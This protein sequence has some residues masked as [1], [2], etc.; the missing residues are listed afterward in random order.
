MIIAHLDYFLGDFF[1]KLSLKI[2]KS[3]IKH[4]FHSDVQVTADCQGTLG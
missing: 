3:F 4:V 1:S 2:V